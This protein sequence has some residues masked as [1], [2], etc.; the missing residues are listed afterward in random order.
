MM[1]FNE[2]S[3]RVAYQLCRTSGRDPDERIP[4]EPY[5]G[6]VVD[7]NGVAYVPLFETVLPEIQNY[8]RITEA[9]KLVVAADRAQGTVQ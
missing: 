3:T 1:D 5:E 8:L 2:L 6:C 4:V 9:V 7:A